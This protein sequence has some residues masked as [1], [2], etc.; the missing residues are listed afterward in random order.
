MAS[1]I[2]KMLR[3]IKNR[4]MMLIG[5]ALI[6]AIDDSKKTQLLQLNLLHDETATDVERFEDYGKASYPLVGSQA[7]TIFQN[8][9]RHHGIVICVHDRRYRPDYLSS[10]EVAIYSHE[11]K[12]ADHRIHLKAGREIEI[13]CNDFTKNVEGD[14]ESNIDGDSTENVDGDK[15]INSNNIAVISLVSAELNA[16][17]VVIGGGIGSGKSICTEDIIDIFNNHVHQGVTVGVANSGVP[18][19]TIGSGNMTSNAKAV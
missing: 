5:R 14:E 3:P 16:P 15:A 8:G 13:S 18:T 1:V 2:E 12:D 4:I 11:D 17:A 7:A 19:T 10:G 6:V 9:N